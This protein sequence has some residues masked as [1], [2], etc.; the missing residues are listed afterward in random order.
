MPEKGYC[1][2]ANT[3][4]LVDAKCPKCE[5]EGPFNIFGATLFRAVTDDGTEDY[6]G[7]E[8]PEPFPAECLACNH[9]AT[10][11]EFRGHT[12]WRCSNCGGVGT[13]EQ[14]FL[15][16]ELD[17]R[18]PDCGSC[19]VSL[20]NDYRAIDENDRGYNTDHGVED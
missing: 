20:N 17:Y 1:T 16:V 8:F 3:N 14:L 13:P 2:V 5:S 19:E 10:Y 6:A 4:V 7:V 11:A 18:C 12:G 15:N 9:V